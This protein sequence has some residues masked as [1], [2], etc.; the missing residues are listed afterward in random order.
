MNEFPKIPK[1]GVL[2]T[3]LIVKVAQ[4]F[5][6]SPGFKI[7]P[8]DW[9]FF[10]IGSMW[11][12]VLSSRSG[13]ASAGFSLSSGFTSG[14]FSLITWFKILRRSAVFTS[15]RDSG[16]S[17]CCRIALTV[18]TSN[19][20]SSFSFSDDLSDCKDTFAPPVGMRTT[21]WLR[22]PGAGDGC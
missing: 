1:V 13:A 17:G 10:E 18:G 19:G 2:L 22:K 7:V 6:V 14:F 20:G 15:L 11:A 4:N 3:R 9:S 12:S 5:I 8:E 21:G 16:K